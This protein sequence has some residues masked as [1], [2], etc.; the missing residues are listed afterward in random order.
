MLEKGQETTIN[1]SVLDYRK[2]VPRLL[3]GWP[4]IPIEVAPIATK[5]VLKAL[6]ELGCPNPELRTLGEQYII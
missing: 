2:D 1:T 6:R 3:T 5:T 4:Y